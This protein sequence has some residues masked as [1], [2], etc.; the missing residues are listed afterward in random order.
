V[1]KKKSEKKAKLNIVTPKGV[2]MFVYLKEPNRKFNPDNEKK[3]CSLLLDRSEPAVQE[4]IRKVD[5]FAEECGVK[6]CIRDAKEE[7]KCRIKAQTTYE[8]PMFD[9]ARGRLP[10]SFDFRGGS[11][12][13][14][15]VSLSP[16]ET[17]GGGLSCYLQG[18]QIFDAR[19]GG[20]ASSMGFEEE[21]G[22][23]YE[24]PEASSEE[25]PF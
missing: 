12:V 20:D 11:I 6:S 13:K 8:V 17:L 21:E 18:I 7:G 1:A 5:E 25:V 2:A 23:V 4:F 14:L 3:E 16:Y 24:K 9:A 10:D 22:F 15:S 19:S